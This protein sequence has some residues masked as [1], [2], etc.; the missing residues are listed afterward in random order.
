[1]TELERRALLGDKDAQRECT[2][3]GIVLPCPCCGGEPAVKVQKVEYG[4]R[5]TI[6]KCQKCG[7]Y[8][9]S[10]DKKAKLIPGAVK[11]VSIQNHKEIG[12]RRWN[13][14][15]DPPIGR[16]GECANSCNAGRQSGD[17]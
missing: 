1:M 6:I 2:E 4:L 14:R 16:C 8:L 5:G 10:P 3:K 7:L 11:N 12:I 13:T 15:P 9:F 17:L